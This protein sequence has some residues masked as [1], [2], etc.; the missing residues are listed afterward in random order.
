MLRSMVRVPLLV[1]AGAC[2]STKEAQVPPPVEHTGAMQVVPLRHRKAVR[3]AGEFE[4]LLASRREW[5][6]LDRDL[7]LDVR[8]DT[9]ANSLVL[10]CRGTIP[11]WVVASIEGL[12]RERTRTTRTIVLQ[13][14]RAADVEQR[15]VESWAVKSPAFLAWTSGSACVMPG[16]MR[17]TVPFEPSSISEVMEDLPRFEAD[18]LTNSMVVSG[19]DT[20]QLV[21]A[22]DWIAELDED[23][24]G[25]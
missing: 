14:A 17:G 4:A 24:R 12:D 3:V 8:A 7:A 21:E 22:L 13:H 10:T 1:L 20:R 19:F 18:T 16:H 15:C 2:T 23:S 6:G 25:R 9:A 5:E 11:D